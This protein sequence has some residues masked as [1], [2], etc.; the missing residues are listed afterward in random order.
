MIPYGNLLDNI[1]LDKLQ[2]MTSHI[3]VTLPKRDG[4]GPGCWTDNQLSLT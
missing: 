2:Y 3:G 4:G 1:G